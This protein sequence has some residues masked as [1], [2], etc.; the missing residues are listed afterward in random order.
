MRSVAFLAHKSLGELYLK[1]NRIDR[2][3]TDLERAIELKPEVADT[4]LTLATAYYECK[5]K[6]KALLAL[7]EY[8]YRGGSQKKASRLEAQI[9]EH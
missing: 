1:Q 6:E 9:N 8:L 2:A 4:Y 7:G 5:D 3:V